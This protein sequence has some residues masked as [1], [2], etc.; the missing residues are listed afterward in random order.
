MRNLNR[1]FVTAITLFVLTS[2]SSAFY[3]YQTGR[4]LNQDPIG[5]QDGV[6]LYA[7]VQSNPV[8]RFDPHGLET[9]QEADARQ[10]EPGNSGLTPCESGYGA[11]C[12]GERKPEIEHVPLPVDES[13]VCCKIRTTNYSHIYVGDTNVTTFA[14]ATNQY[15]TIDNPDKF[16]PMDACRSFTGEDIIRGRDGST[17]YDIYEAHVGKCCMCEVYL[18][19]NDIGWLGHIP[20]VRRF[21]HG[22]LLVLCDDPSKSWDLDVDPD[23]DDSTFIGYFGFGT[24]NWLVGDRVDAEPFANKQYKRLGTI[25]CDTADKYH[26]HMNS[27][28]GEEFY[29]STLTENCHSTAEKLARVMVRYSYCGDH[30]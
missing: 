30:R 28:E 1:V 9:W 5:Y 3:D 4:W 12:G 29:Y 20:I 25:D 14:N 27:L 23:V 10:G 8:N 16:N 21:S 6:N 7:Y 17:T 18:I 24:A 13:K 22:G 2:H 26:E 11:D 19:W 15:L